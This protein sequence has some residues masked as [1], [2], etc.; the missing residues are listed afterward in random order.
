MVIDAVNEEHLILVV[1]DVVER[2]EQAPGPHHRTKSVNREPNRFV[3]LSDGGLLIAFPRLDTSTR[4]VPD[5]VLR[6]SWVATAQEQD[7]LPGVDDQYSGRPTA[8]G[9]HGLRL[10]ARPTE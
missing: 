5:D 4:G 1:L 2:E 9:S 3:Q 8:D 6:P 7:S 10:L